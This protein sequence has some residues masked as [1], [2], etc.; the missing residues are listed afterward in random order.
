[1]INQYEVMFLFNP[2]EAVFQSSIE[3]VKKI[4]TE[5]NVEIEKEDD[6]GIRELAYEIKKAKDAHYYLFHIKAESTSILTI[7]KEIQLHEEI[8]RFLFVKKLFKKDR[9]AKK[10][11]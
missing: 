8:P 9:Y 4:F 6:M 2:N 7:T 3:T 10:R 1:M 5:Q 11:A